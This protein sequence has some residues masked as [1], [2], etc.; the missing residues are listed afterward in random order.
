MALT[1]LT[2]EDKVKLKH[3]K[4]EAV[5]T[6]Q[7]IKDLRE[8][9]RDTVKAVAEQIEVEPKTLNLMIKIA[10]KEHLNEGSINTEE[11]VLEDIKHLLHA[12]DTAAR[13]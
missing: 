3:L 7:K 2:S 8:A 12:A 11:E 1:A 4:E 13:D 5:D 9:L 6:L 10:F